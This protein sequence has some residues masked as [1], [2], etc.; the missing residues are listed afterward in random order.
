[1]S[2]EELEK[3]LSERPSTKEFRQEL[4]GEWVKAKDLEKFEA[5]EEAI[6]KEI[7]KERAHEVESLNEALRSSKPWSLDLPVHPPIS[8]EIHFPIVNKK[9][10]PFVEELPDGHVSPPIDDDAFKEF[11]MPIIKQ[12]FPKSKIEDLISKQP[13]GTPDAVGASGIFDLKTVNQPNTACPLPPGTCETCLGNGVRPGSGDTCGACNGSGMTRD[14]YKNWLDRKAKRLAKT[15]EAI[16]DLTNAARGAGEAAEGLVEVLEEINR[17]TPEEQEIAD[18]LE[19]ELDECLDALYDPANPSK[20]IVIPMTERYLITIAEYVMGRF[21]G[22]QTKYTG[23]AFE[24]SP[25]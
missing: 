7:M 5:E 22:W 6:H 8:G 21:T 15:S 4:L 16:E 9:V 17:L 12:G 13:L 18:I 1:M 20:K 10:K 2:R 23:E 3:L 11:V 19:K 24:F 14:E 25:K